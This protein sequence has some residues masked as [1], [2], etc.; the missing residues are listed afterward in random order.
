MK[1]SDQPQEAKRAQERKEGI[2]IKLIES[3]FYILIVL[4]AMVVVPILLNHIFSLDTPNWFSPVAGTTAVQQTWIGFAGAFLGAIIGAVVTVYVMSKTIKDNNDSLIKTIE[5]DN[6]LHKATMLRRELSVIQS[7]T[8]DLIN[9]IGKVFPFRVIN[10]LPVRDHADLI[11]KTTSGHKKQYRLNQCEFAKSKGEFA[12]ALNLI[13]AHYDNVTDKYRKFKNY[14]LFDNVC[15]EQIDMINENV[16]GIQKTLSQF[17]ENINFLRFVYVSNNI[18]D[19]SGI[20]YDLRSKY[21][22][23]LADK[24]SWLEIPKEM[25]DDSGFI[26]KDKMFFETKKNFAQQLAY[27][28]F[29][30]SVQKKRFF[31]CNNENDLKTIDIFKDIEDPKSAPY[32]VVY[33]CDKDTLATYLKKL[34]LLKRGDEEG[35]EMFNAFDHYLK[36]SSINTIEYMKQEE[37]LQLIP[38]FFRLDSDHPVVMPID[39]EM[40]EKEGNSPRVIEQ[41]YEELFEEKV[42]S[43]YDERFGEC[44]D[45]ETIFENKYNDFTWFLKIDGI[46]WLKSYLD[47]CLKHYE[48]HDPEIDSILADYKQ[49]AFS[50]IGFIF[51]DVYQPVY[52]FSNDFLRDYNDKEVS[53]LESIL[54]GKKGIVYSIRDKVNE[55]E[56]SGKE[57]N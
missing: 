13:K 20:N 9:E 48:R 14:P 21:I 28:Y 56:A 34:I 42:K 17:K 43:D 45:P 53:Y 27:T 30:W 12:K 15:Q 47:H 54:I 36:K 33:I 51:I 1:G 31:A 23:D 44:S 8:Y 16:E 22:P 29:L 3:L 37:Q 32:N 39:L 50:H 5:H 46:D 24:A 52:L 40:K 57:S 38:F 55:L 25:S 26:I 6:K 18:S 41:L 49:H 35:A 11:K 10:Y 7:R 4:C 19:Q 2:I